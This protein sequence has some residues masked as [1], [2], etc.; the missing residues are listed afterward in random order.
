MKYVSTRG[1]TPEQTFEGVLLSGLA[2]DGGLFV[3]AEWPAM[4][5]AGIAALDG[6]DYPDIV[7]RIVR[8]FIEP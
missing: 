1:S 4:D 7:A 3:P 8:P 6:M 2:R 5:N